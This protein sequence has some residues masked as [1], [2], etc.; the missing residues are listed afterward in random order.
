MRKHSLIRIT[1]S[2]LFFGGKMVIERLLAIVA[3]FVV[4]PF[5][6]FMGLM[7]SLVRKFQRLHLS[8][9]TGTQKTGKG[10]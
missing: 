5:L 7:V 10:D 2:I 9:I 8:L 3:I 4:A 1:G 6:I